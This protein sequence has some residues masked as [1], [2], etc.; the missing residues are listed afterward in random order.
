[1]NELDNKQDNFNIVL[2][3]DT[4]ETNS[5][6]NLVDGETNTN[7]L[8]IID[9]RTAK[10]KKKRKLNKRKEKDILI[11]SLLA[12]ATK[13]SKEQCMMILSSIADGTAR[14]FTGLP[15]SLETRIKAIDKLMPMIETE[16]SG[17]LNS[18]T[19]N[20]VDSSNDN[21]VKDLENKIING[22]K[23]SKAL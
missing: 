7:D 14:D 16:P 15:P 20:I 3:R 10:S 21:K 18:I 13:L 6:D 4:N 22:N 19:V 1:M 5:N 8:L 2:N 17:Q 11:D 9:N 23:D 12:V